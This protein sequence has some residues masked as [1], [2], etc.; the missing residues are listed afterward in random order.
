M[1]RQTWNRHILADYITAL[2]NHASR[3][4]GPIEE[5]IRKARQLQAERYGTNQQQAA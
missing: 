3:K 5:R 4:Y 1:H 2:E